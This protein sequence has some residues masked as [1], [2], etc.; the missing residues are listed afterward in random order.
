M[1][2][3]VRRRASPYW[4]LQFKRGKKWGKRATKYR[5]S[6]SADTRK[7]R[8]ECARQTLAEITATGA[9]GESRWEA[10]VPDFF[11]QRYA[12]LPATRWRYE[13]AW[14]TW[15]LFFDKHQILGPSDL[16]YTHCMQFLKWRQNPDVKGVYKGGRNTAIFEIKVLGT[17]VQEAVRRGF[18]AVNPTRGLGLMKTKPREKPEITLEEEAIIRRELPNWPEWMQVGLE[19]AMAT[20]CRLRETSIDFRNVDFQKMT[21]RLMTKGGRTHTTVLPP[22]LLPLLQ[23][24]KAEGRQRTCELPYMPSKQW[25]L[26]FR[27]VGLRHLCF[28]CTRVTVIT[29][30][31]RAGIPERHAMRFVGHASWTI[32]RVYTR[33][34]VDDLKSCVEALSNATAPPPQPTP[35]AGA[36]AT[37]APGPAQCVSRD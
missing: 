29:R 7:A 5:H 3:L 2:I 4:Y 26:F 1:S 6:V 31:A 13:T 20:G 12:T 8:E 17:I 24:L 23:K 18:A 25:W 27:K 19:I 21:I 11:E 16:N 9:K 14:R 28:H 35:Q 30:L 33:L 22:K 32:H 36:A 37:D 34:H 15:L 10:W